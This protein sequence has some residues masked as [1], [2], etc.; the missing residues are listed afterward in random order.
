M[1]KR[2]AGR[3]VLGRPLRTIT[4]KLRFWYGGAAVKNIPSASKSELVLV[5]FFH[6]GKG[7]DAIKLGL[8]CRSG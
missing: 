3:I 7:K 6:D 5:D 1:R 4:V 2:R 8:D